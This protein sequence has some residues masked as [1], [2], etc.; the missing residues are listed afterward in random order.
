VTY[1]NLANRFQWLYFSGILFANSL[2]PQSSAQEQAPQRSEAIE[3]KSP[4]DSSRQTAGTDPGLSLKITTRLVV[5]DVVARDKKDQVILD[6][7]APDFKIFEDGK[8]QRIGVFNFQH[9][10]ESDVALPENPA[11]SPNLYR[12]TPHYSSN[13]ALNVILVDAL[14]TTFLNQVY[15][16]AE[17]VKFIEKL[18]Q[19]QPIAIFTLGRKLRMLQDFTAD[20]TQLKNVIQAL[21]GESS[22][23]LSDPTGTSA[24]P[25]TLQGAA[26]QVAIDMA[27]QLRAQ[28]QDF[29]DQSVADQ[30]DDRI[31]Y[32]LNALTSL[33]RMLAGYAGRKN[34]IWLSESIPFGV[35]PDVRGLT[36]DSK[37]IRA[38]LGD[39]G[40]ANVKNLSANKREYVDQLALISNLLA[41]A[42][43]SV[44]P[45]D[46]RGLVG[47]AFFNVAN[48]VGGQ[49]GAGAL[50]SKI[51]GKQADEL[52]QAHYNMRDI[53]EKTGG[54]AFYN[55]NDLD[56]AVRN[57][58]N[59]G[60]TYYMIGYYSSN[61][62]WNGQFRKIQL[63]VNRPGAKLR[64]RLG[65]YA[66][67][68]A[69]FEKKH[70]EQRN[71][72]LAAAL[73]PDYPTATAIQFEATVLPPE[74]GQTKVRIDY[75]INSSYLGFQVDAN[76]LQRVQVDCAA[77]VFLQ[78]DIDHPLKSEATRVNG[79]LQ[80]EVFEK[81]KKSYFPC[82][83]SMDLPPA[84]H[85]LLRL[86]VRDN[87][88][89]QV[90][91]VNAEVTVP[92]VAAATKR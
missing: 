54:L 19:G 37:D 55:R 4:S 27:P 45:V 50:V 18:P 29:A 63:R 15:V 87:T 73:N 16:R 39:N 46:A 43:V 1:N 40:P 13:R 89:G 74:P 35:Y 81:I 23:V 30:S 47:G 71:Y 52:F 64:Y 83:L 78:K 85:Y 42:Q 34:L 25:M 5:I 44:Y 69:E 9:P 2:L 11:R 77:R 20:L 3:Q 90:G 75:A 72:D 51:E 76:G 57:G 66:V 79:A 32:T 68:R 65:Y 67:D 70:P 38:Q 6:L 58:I 10:V 80:P 82:Q 36:R 61:K 17:M 41:D 31:Q 62:T 22:H 86:A 28:I 7:Q 12:N 84:A 59:D 91:T 33:A 14:N 48:N 21:K 56:V 24:V 26:D 8:E 92:V 88:T 49:A 60:S 53:A